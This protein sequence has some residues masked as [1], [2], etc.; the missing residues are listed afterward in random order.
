MEQF[1][2][3]EENP[4]IQQ[5]SVDVIN[6]PLVGELANE[7]VEPKYQNVLSENNKST[8]PADFAAQEL[9]YPTLTAAVIAYQE[10]ISS[11]KETQIEPP[12][13]SKENREFAR[14]EKSIWQFIDQYSKSLLRKKGISENEIDGI[15]SDVNLKLLNTFSKRG[16]QGRAQFS[17]YLYLVI[18]NAAKTNLAKPKN[19]HEVLVDVK[20]PSGYMLTKANLVDERQDTASLIEQRW[21]YKNLLTWLY[22]ALDNDNPNKASKDRQFARLKFLEGHKDRQ[23]FLLLGMASLAATK[24][25]GSRLRKVLKEAK[26]QIDQAD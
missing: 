14:L 24:V 19:K 3:V 21:Q 15:I 8:K 12:K 26:D 10:I 7:T 25:Y 9:G 6:V 20:D 18:D 16:F 4:V 13:E 1:N 5:P 23:I 17:T 11:Q 22:Y 2:V